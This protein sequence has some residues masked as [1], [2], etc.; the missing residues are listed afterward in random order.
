METWFRNTR[1][2][3]AMRVQNMILKLWTGLKECWLVLLWALFSLHFLSCSSGSCGVPC[4]GCDSGLSFC[5]GK[6]DLRNSWFFVLGCMVLSWDCSLALLGCARSSSAW[7]WEDCDGVRMDCIAQRN[8]ILHWSIKVAT[9]SQTKGSPD[10]GF[11]A[12]AGRSDCRGRIVCRT[13]PQTS[14]TTQMREVMICCWGQK[15]L[16]A[17]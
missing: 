9:L 7:M 11:L 3:L 8:W 14:V 4:C 15:S 5:G 17:S 12:V 13:A 10:P 1:F 6:V 16:V 2:L